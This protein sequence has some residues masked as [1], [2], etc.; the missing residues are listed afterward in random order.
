M[1]LSPRT[2]IAVI[3][4]DLDQLEVFKHFFMEQ[5][6]YDV[7]YYT[8]HKDFRK[9]DLESFD[10][11]I[12]DHT[13]EKMLGTDLIEACYGKT[14]ARFALISTWIESIFTAENKKNPKISGLIAKY[15]GDDYNWDGILRWISG[16]E[17]NIRAM[18]KLF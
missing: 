7:E 8:G 11:V 14:H 10:L 2:R 5:P 13:L 4:D 1:S 18:K 12:V 6:E 9:A 3:D 15:L 16:Q 17:I